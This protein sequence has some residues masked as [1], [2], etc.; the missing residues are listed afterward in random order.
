MDWIKVY[1]KVLAAAVCFI[2]LLLLFLW[3]PIYIEYDLFHDESYASS[4]MFFVL[5]V[6]YAILCL[7]VSGFVLLR[8]SRKDVK[9]LVRLVTFICFTIVVSAIRE[10]YGGITSNSDLVLI[11]CVPLVLCFLVHVIHLRMLKKSL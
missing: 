11:I 8:Y 6:S 10:Q 7:L 9:Y 5:I 3:V 4:H 2:G 1:F